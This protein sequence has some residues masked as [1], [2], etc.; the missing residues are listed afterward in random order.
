M[1]ISERRNR[2]AGVALFTFKEFIEEEDEVC[3]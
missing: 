2:R 1:A 3:R